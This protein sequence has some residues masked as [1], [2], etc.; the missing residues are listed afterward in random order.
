M[1]IKATIQEQNKY[2]SFVHSTI[3][4]LGAIMRFAVL[5]ILF[6]SCRSDRGRIVTLNEIGWSFELP[7]NL[8]FSDSAF[9]S[10]GLIDKS[11]WDTSS[12]DPRFRV[13]LFWIK[14]EKKNYF[15][16]IIHV[17]S[18]E[19]NKW[20]QDVLV[21][22]R[23]YI[24][25]VRETPELKLLDTLISVENIDG[26]NLQKEYIKIFNTVT[27]DTTYSYKFSRKY[28]NYSINMNIKFIDPRLGK[29]FLYILNSSR[30]D[31]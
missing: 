27:K 7:A 20:A 10:Q 14:P 23:F 30:F 3:H 25:L 18:S 16:T 31:K 8:S 9:N 2:E 22:S 1:S 12:F 11:L 4:T 26:V 13:E 17:D 15:N 24:S 5:I 6:L 21:D 29:E 28:K 19:H